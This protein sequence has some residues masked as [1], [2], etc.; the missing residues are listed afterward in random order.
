MMPR[1]PAQGSLYYQRQRHWLAPRRINGIIMS[2]G[3]SFKSLIY[4]TYNE[5]VYRYNDLSFTAGPDGT[6]RAAQLPNHRYGYSVSAELLDKEADV[7]PGDNI[8]GRPESARHLHLSRQGRAIQ[9][10]SR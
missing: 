2:S 1:R 10:A 3:N 5:K 8:I 6:G 9:S 7:C 4:L